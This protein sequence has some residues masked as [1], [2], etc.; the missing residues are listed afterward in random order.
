MQHQLFRARTVYAELANEVRETNASEVYPTPIW[1][2]QDLLEYGPE[3][4]KGCL[5]PGCVWQDP[6]AGNGR[7]PEAVNRWVSGQPLS[8]PQWQLLEK[9]KSEELA[10]KRFD[11]AFVS[12]GDY[13]TSIDIARQLKSMDEPDVVIMNSPFKLTRRFIE[14]IWGRYQHA[15]VVSLQR[16]S[17]RGSTARAAWVGEHQPRIYTFGAHRSRPSF[18]ADR[19]TDGAEY[20][21][22][23]WLAHERD[24]REIPGGHTLQP[25]RETS[26][27][28]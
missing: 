13:L 25:E 28:R 23:V 18:R 16:Q 1:C 10:L 5:L 19:K 24:R 6:C 3:T 7:I 12:I 21:W 20:E 27:T 2:V 4:L 26:C 22:H 8:E 14:T 9:R 17:W 15:H 11:D